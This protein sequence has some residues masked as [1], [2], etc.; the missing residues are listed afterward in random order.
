MENKKYLNIVTYHK[1][2][3]PNGTGNLS[4]APNIQ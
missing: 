2:N 4:S 3:A 1:E